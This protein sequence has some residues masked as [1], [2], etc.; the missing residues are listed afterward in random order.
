MDVDQRQGDTGVS[1]YPPT[2]GERNF[3]ARGTSTACGAEPDDETR[4]QPTV[5][6]DSE[7]R[8]R[9]GRRFWQPSSGNRK[10]RRPDPLQFPKTR[11]ARLRHTERQRLFFPRARSCTAGSPTPS[12]ALFG[13]LNLREIFGFGG[14]QENAGARQGDTGVSTFPPAEGE[15]LSTVPL[16]PSAS[17]NATPA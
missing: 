15:R 11:A 7:W 14:A 13:Q 3:T 12:R 16:R 17:D 8:K 1:R 2:E 9:I 6:N 4:C 5:A 10:R